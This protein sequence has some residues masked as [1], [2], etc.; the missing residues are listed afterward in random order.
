MLR[1]EKNDLQNEFTAM[2]D[3]YLNIKNQ[4]QDFI[5]KKQLVI[6]LEREVEQLTDENT[7]IKSTAA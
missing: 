2:Q 4:Q 6:K 1:K 5:A 7:Q 3:D